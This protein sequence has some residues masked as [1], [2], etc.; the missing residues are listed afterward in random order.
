MGA[1]FLISG[2]ALANE[3]PT[4]APLDHGLWWLY[5]L[6]YDK[7]LAD[8]RYLYRRVIQ[9]IPPAIFIARPLIGGIW[10]KSLNTAFLKSKSSS[11]Q[12]RKKRVEVVSVPFMIP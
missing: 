6:Q 3:P 10:P 12:T 1:L 9:K 8:F 4:D 5:H 7:A 2:T 11:K